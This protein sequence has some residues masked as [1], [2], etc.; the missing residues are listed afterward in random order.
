[1]FVDIDLSE[2]TFVIRDMITEEKLYKIPAYLMDITN[3]KSEEN[4]RSI[5]NTMRWVG[6]DKL[7]IL[8]KKGIEKLVSIK[9]DFKQLNYNYISNLNWQKEVLRSFYF[10]R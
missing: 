2:S 1:M 7:K 6:N 5:F 9:D 4:I 3:D 10:N 8:N